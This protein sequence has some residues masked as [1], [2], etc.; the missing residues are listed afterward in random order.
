MIYFFVNPPNP[1][2][3]TADTEYSNKNC[4]WVG[5]PKLKLRQPFCLELCYFCLLKPV[6]TD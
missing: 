3:L 5:L 6:R 4:Y 1:Q 2:I